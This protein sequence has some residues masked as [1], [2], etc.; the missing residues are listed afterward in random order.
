MPGEPSGIV[1]GKGPTL[2]IC[3]RFDLY[4]CMMSSSGGMLR[5]F[6]FPLR[7]ASMKPLVWKATSTSGAWPEALSASPGSIAA[8]LSAVMVGSNTGMEGRS[9]H[10]HYGAT[11]RWQSR[12]V[13]GDWRS[14]RFVVER[15]RGT[16]E[17]GC[18][19]TEEGLCFTHAEEAFVRSAF[20]S[21]RIDL[22]IG[23]FDL[24]E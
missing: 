11:F 9:F 21:L 15:L 12:L 14:E 17:V 3:T 19:G 7:R 16:G 24:G 10:G 23:G 1:C 6:A 18:A 13:G 4:C 20:F 5:R 2:K 8:A 22:G